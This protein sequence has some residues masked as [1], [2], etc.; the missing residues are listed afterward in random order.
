M[1]A[2]D[3]VVGEISQAQTTTA[4][5]LMWR[6]RQIKDDEKLKVKIWVSA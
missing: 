6:L 5:S 4:F 1:Y 3:P 2:S